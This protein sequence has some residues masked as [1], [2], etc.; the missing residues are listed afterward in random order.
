MDSIF[1]NTAMISVIIVVVIFFG[2]V[3]MISRFYHKASQGQALVRTG[4]WAEFAYHS[5]ACW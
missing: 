3:A 1:Q 5:M 2:I 4:S